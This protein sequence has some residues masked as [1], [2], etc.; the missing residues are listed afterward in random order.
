MDV[1]Q[2]K[3]TLVVDAPKRNEIELGI[4]LAYNT[5][6]WKKQ[7]DR[8]GARAIEIAKLC[9]RSCLFLRGSGDAL[10]GLASASKFTSSLHE[11]TSEE[12]TRNK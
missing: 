3:S 12:E 6:L 10:G 1:S 4:A 2:G 9:Y 11:E 8:S 5:K 7:V